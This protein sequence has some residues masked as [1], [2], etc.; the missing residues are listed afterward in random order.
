MASLILYG[1]L[2]GSRVPLAKPVY[3]RP[4][5]RPDPADLQV[6]RRETTPDNSLLAFYDFP[7]EHWQHLLTTDPIESTFATVRHRTTR[8]RNCVSRP[9]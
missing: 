6:P 2:D 1:E 4:I 8:T 7:T 5:L 9:A 3:A